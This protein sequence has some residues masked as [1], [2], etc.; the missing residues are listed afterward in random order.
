MYPSCF[1][2]NYTYHR[3][4]QIFKNDYDLDLIA[5]I[6]YKG[7]RYAPKKYNL[8]RSNGT[9]ELEN[10]T[11]DTLRQYLTTEGYTLKDE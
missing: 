8:V 10:V 6:S 5:V 2:L 11:L 9:I 1:T 7:T 3:I 4:K